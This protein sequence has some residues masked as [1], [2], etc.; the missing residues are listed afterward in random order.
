MNLVDRLRTDR[1]EI[2][3]RV[4]DDM[5]TDPFWNERFAA[6][7]RKHSEEDLA[8]HVDY[9]IQAVTNGEAAVM[10]NYARWLQTILTTR[11]MCTLHLADSFGR[12]ALAISDPTA[13][14][15]LAAARSALLYSGGTARAL[16]E[17]IRDAIVT[18]TPD[19]IEDTA[20]HLAYL[21]DAVAL[22]QPAIFIDHVKW[23]KSFVEKQGRDPHALASTLEAITRTLDSDQA[24]TIVAAAL[25][26]LA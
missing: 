4:I 11:G 13:T 2:A 26:E 9:L 23:L 7:G 25:K 19:G 3:G 5:Y 16:Q 18:G 21:A 10:E 1:R 22:G 24:K 17:R 15:Y 8:F 14:P 6:R 12:L 20:Y